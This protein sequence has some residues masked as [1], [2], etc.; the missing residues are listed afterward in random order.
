LSIFAVVSSHF[1]HTNSL[2][3]RLLPSAIQQPRRTN[4]PAHFQLPRKNDGF[5]FFRVA[6][7]IATHICFLFLI[8]NAF[9]MMIQLK[10]FCA[11][12][13]TGRVPGRITLTYN[14]DEILIENESKVPISGFVSVVATRI[15]KGAIVA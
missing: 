6:E 8:M 2:L 1:A 15:T 11:N 14:L 9:V 13:A 12:F 7:C 10:L 4:R 5:L 3:E